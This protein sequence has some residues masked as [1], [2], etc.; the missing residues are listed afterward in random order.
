M[1]T[2]WIYCRIDV[3]VAASSADVREAMAKWA[4]ASVK[5]GRAS[6]TEAMYLAVLK[7]H[8]DAFVRYGAVMSGV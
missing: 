6:L 1:T 8:D 3:H 4:D 7:E 2:Y 5:G